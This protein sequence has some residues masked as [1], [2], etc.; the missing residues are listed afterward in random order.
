MQAIVLQLVFKGEGFHPT[1][2]VSPWLDYAAKPYDEVLDLCAEQTHRRVL[3]T[4]TPLD[5]F[6]LDHDSSY[7]VVS[8]D[9][10]DVFMSLWNHFSSYSKE[11]HARL[12]D[13]PD[14]I[15]APQP[16]CPD[17][18]RDFWDMWIGRGWFD[19]ETEGYPFW[20]NFHHVQTWWDY[21][22]LPNIHFVHFNNLLSDLEGEIAGIAKFL[23]IECEPDLVSKIA[24]KVTFS[25]MKRD[26]EK[27]VGKMDLIDG[28]AKTFINKGTNGR[29]KD[30]LTETDL[31]AYERTAA[32]T[33]SPDCRAWLET[34]VGYDG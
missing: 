22:H 5:G 17:N 25:S 10:R 8:R 12:N 29:W 19:W 31:Q 23:Q 30:V 27:F 21:R 3:K 18:I 33:L 24:D 1:N 28:G 34:G 16:P 14:R 6:E 13:R 2:E 9:P 15:G 20:S 7:I 26:A 32:R 11:G 4:H